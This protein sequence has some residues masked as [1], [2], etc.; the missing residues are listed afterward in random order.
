[1][2][3]LCVDVC[4]CPDEAIRHISNEFNKIN[5]KKLN[6]SITEVNHGDSTSIICSISETNDSVADPVQIYKQLSVCVS[7]ALADYIVNK[8]E[9]KLIK[10]TI[11]SNY[12][13]FCSSDKKEISNFAMSNLRSEEKNFLHSILQMRR[14]NIIVQKLIDYFEGSNTLMIDGFVNFRLKE[15]IKDLEEIT[16]KAVDDFLMEKEYREFVRLLRYFVDVQEPKFEIIHIVIDYYGKYVLVDDTGREI[17]YECIQEFIDEISDGEINYDDLLVS[18]LIT[19][20]PKQILIH[21]VERFKNKEL[22]ET[23][24]NVFWSKVRICNE[25]DICVS[26]ILNSKN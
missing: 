20:A 23:I 1:M 3:F 9:E 5:N 10:R 8:Y 13:Y 26:V 15:Y 14:R 2:Q 19:L 17:T 12:C 7:D 18:S 22:I 6:Y 25:C 16:D 4:E 21:G 11:N 24:K